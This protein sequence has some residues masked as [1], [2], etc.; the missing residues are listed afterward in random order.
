MCW[1]DWQAFGIMT[2]L[3][4]ERKASPGGARFHQEHSSVLVQREMGSGA[5]LVSEYTAISRASLDDTAQ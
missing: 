3:A 5:F 2:R 4:R 1:R